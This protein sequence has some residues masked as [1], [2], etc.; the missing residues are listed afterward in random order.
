[1][2]SPPDPNTNTIN[3]TVDTGNNAFS[4]RRVDFDITVP[5]GANL[6]FKVTSGDINVEGVSGQASLITESGNI[7]TS[8][9][10]FSANAV[11][12][13][14]SGDIRTSRDMFNGQ[15]EIST[16]SGDVSLEQDTL[17]GSS[18][19]NTTSGDIHFN[20]TVDP[21]QKYLFQAVS[22][23]IDIG[24][25]GSTDFQVN[26][27]TT[28]GSIHTDGFPGLQVQEDNTGPGSQVS[29]QV[30]AASGASFTIHTTSGDITIHQNG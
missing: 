10:N 25:P 29:G 5:Q 1:N 26:G 12:Q 7:T 20:G 17:N 15:S 13:T 16:T 27:S 3:V 14:T 24:L 30:G 21:T 23:D 4:A 22:G 6:Q 2:V 8:D 18:T 9:D 19:I 11:L 28:S